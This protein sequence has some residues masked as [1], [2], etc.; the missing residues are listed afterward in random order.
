MPDIRDVYAEIET[1]EL[2][3]LHA[4][5]EAITQ[6]APRIDGTSEPDYD[7]L[8]DGPLSEL[9]AINRALRKKVAA[10]AGTAKRAASP[11]AKPA[12]KSKDIGDLL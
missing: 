5:R 12:S 7:K 1:W 9:L 2:P 10:N 4:R 6:S 3:Q 8:E 11:R